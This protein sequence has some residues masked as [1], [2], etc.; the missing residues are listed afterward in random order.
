MR[1]NENKG[2]LMNK[3]RDYVCNFLLINIICHISVK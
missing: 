1:Y 3:G 2:L